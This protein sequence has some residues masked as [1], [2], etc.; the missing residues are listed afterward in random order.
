MEF[1]G[2]RAGLKAVDGKETDMLIVARFMQNEN[3]DKF[4]DYMSEVAARLRTME[5]FSDAMAEFLQ[6][7][8]NTVRDAQTAE[9]F[10]EEVSFEPTTQRRLEK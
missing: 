8:E 5:P 10:M 7:V 6:A 9:K 2:T 4:G 1:H 3:Q